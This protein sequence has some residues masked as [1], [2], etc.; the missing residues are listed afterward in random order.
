MQ[1]LHRISVLILIEALWTCFPMSFLCPFE[2]R[3]FFQGRFPGRKN[4]LC[5]GTF[6]V[7]WLGVWPMVRMS[8]N[9]KRQ[10]GCCFFFHVELT[11]KSFWLMMWWSWGGWKQCW[12]FQVKFWIYHNEIYLDSFEVLFFLPDFPFF[13]PD[14]LHQSFTVA[15]SWPLCSRWAWWCHQLWCDWQQLNCQCF[16]HKYPYRS[17]WK[18]RDGM[19][20]AKWRNKSLNVNTRFPSHKQFKILS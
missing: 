12:K 8:S 10:T 1:V 6:E 17:Y 5:T 14:F 11:F 15:G 9:I 16:S 4:T 3:E 2:L 19:Q 20:F 7:L 18:W 13:L